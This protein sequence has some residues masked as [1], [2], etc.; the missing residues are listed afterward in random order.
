MPK[1]GGRFFNK[2]SLTDSNPLIDR[3]ITLGHYFNS[4][5]LYGDVV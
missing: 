4:A 5:I 2:D 1:Q 3:I